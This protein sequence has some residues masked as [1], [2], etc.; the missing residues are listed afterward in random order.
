MRARLL[1]A[2]IALIAVIA[3]GSASAHPLSRQECSE[4]SDFIRNA[5]LSRDNG[6]DGMMFLS[7]AIDDIAAI[8]SFPRELRWFVQDERDEDFLLKAISRVFSEPL[9]PQSHQREFLAACLQ[10][11]AAID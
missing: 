9:D 4:G 2:G 1:P 3:T 10:R 8:R 7:R 6:I 11:S 5:A